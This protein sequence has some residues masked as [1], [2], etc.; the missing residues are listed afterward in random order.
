MNYVSNVKKHGLILGM[1]FTDQIIRAISSSRIGSDSDANGK[2]F[3]THC[4]AHNSIKCI[5]EWIMNGKQWPK[6]FYQFIF[7]FITQ[8][9]LGITFTFNKV[10]AVVANG[11]LNSSVD[12]KSVKTTIKVYGVTKCRNVRSL[13][14]YNC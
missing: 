13:S 14:L 10:I 7:I 11:R 8:E 6:R 2:W 4:S 12:Y 1:Q 3:G 9:C 5:D